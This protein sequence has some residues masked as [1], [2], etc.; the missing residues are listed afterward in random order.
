MTHQSEDHVM[1]TIQ[2]LASAAIAFASLPLMMAQQVNTQAQESVSGSAG[3]A[4]VNQSANAGANANAESGDAQGRATVGTAVAATGNGPANISANG[5]GRAFNSADMRP[6][7]G[8][9]EG[10]LDS[11]TAKPGDQVVLK[12]GKRIQ[13]A[14]G[15]VI[16]KGSRLVGRVTDVQA[17]QKGHEESHIGLQ[18]DRAELKGGQTMAIHSTIES[19]QPS[20]SALADSSMAAADSLDTPMVGGGGAVGGSAMTA[21]RVGGGG[22]LGGAAGGATMATERVGSDLGATAGSA[23]RTTGNLGGQTTGSL[24]RGV[25]GAAR[26][27]GSLGAHATGFPG[28]MLNGD[29]TGSASGMLSAA[30]K[31][32]HLDSGTQMILG[33]AAAR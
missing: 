13:T 5:E 28:V 17:H 21:G 6:V 10:K 7:T 4:Q 12:T 9:L 33:V 2:L 25:S 27:A 30:N 18:F 3:S 20:A 14:D 26:G 31:N 29:A 24:S 11:K 1:K 15:T 32:I 22:L 23:V 8:E 16:P 19:M